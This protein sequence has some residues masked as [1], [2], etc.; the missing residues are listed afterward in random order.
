MAFQYLTI[1]LNLI[2]K[3]L[4]FLGTCT[5]MYKKGKMEVLWYICHIY[6]YRVLV[7]SP[8]LI[9]SELY[10][11]Q[12]I[13]ERVW[14]SIIWYMVH[15]PLNTLSLVLA[16]TPNPYYNTTHTHTLSEKCFIYKFIQ[17]R[18]IYDICYIVLSY[19]SCRSF[20]L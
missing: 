13:W 10:W 3:Y 7:N 15:A 14:D 12:V 1:F 11:S 9:S 5:I 18:Y 20:T 4:F 6:I 2:F 17:L 19:L 8:I 16:R